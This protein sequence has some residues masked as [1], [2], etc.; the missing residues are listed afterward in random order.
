MLADLI[1]G[2]DVGMVEVGHR[3][4]LGPKTGDVAR[5]CQG[6]LE[7]HLEGDDPVQRDLPGLVDDAHPSPR[8][9]LDQLVIAEVADADRDG[10]SI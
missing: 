5:G 1:N 3:L 2:D 4:G 7:N 6:T 8:D 9:L 10:G